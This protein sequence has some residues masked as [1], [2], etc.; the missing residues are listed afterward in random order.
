MN[1]QNRLWPT[2]NYSLSVRAPD[3][4]VE[5]PINTIV[6]AFGVFALEICDSFSIGHGELRH[7]FETAFERVKYCAPK[8]E[9]GD[10]FEATGRQR[11]V[12]R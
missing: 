4:V 2:K 3:K 8:V 7:D 12:G 1:R 9:A 5:T 10:F 6:N 11:G